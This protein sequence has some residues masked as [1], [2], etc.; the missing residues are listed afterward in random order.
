MALYYSLPI[1][2]E[3][4]QLILI[5]FEA[6]R[7]F[8]REYKYTLGQ[9]MKRDGLE[10]VRSVYRANK[11]ENKEED[12]EEILDKLEIIKLQTR[13]ASDLKILSIKKQTQIAKGI[14]SVGRQASGWKKNFSKS[15]GIA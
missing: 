1:Y 11:K 3:I 12:I 7:K 10:L 4:Y 14:E 15:A 13:L 2:K 5:L 9:D 8:P 6:T